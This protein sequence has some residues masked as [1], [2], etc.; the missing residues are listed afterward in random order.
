MQTTQT[1]MLRS[2]ENVKAFLN[3]HASTLTGVVSTGTRQELDDAIGELS[4][5][6]ADQSG[7]LIEARD[8]TRKQRLARTVLL[9]D[10]MRPIARVALHKL[11]PTP[12]SALRMPRGNPST[13]RLGNVAKAMAQAAE[14]STAVFV[15]AGLPA[16]FITQLNSAAD[17]MLDSLKDRKKSQGKVKGAT[18]GL[19]T[20]LA[21]GRRVVH[22]LDAFVRSAL[23]GNSVLLA[24]W[25]VVKRVQKPRVHTPDISPANPAIQAVA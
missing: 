19:Q 12:D 7:H 1:N 21:A 2:L 17:A 18:D 10:H 16:D 15:G 4:V 25:D 22:I 11:S 20:R 13:E 24:N 3:E 9:R 6:I 8:A 14:P 5:H 23:T